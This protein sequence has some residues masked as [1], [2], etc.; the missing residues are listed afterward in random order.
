MKLDT[1]LISATKSLILAESKQTLNGYKGLYICF[2][3]FRNRVI[4]YSLMRLPFRLKA[5]SASRDVLGMITSA[6]ISTVSSFKCIE[7]IQLQFTSLGQLDIDI[8]VN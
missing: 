2:K 5:R 7:G 3:G 1:T 4:F 8:R 6:T